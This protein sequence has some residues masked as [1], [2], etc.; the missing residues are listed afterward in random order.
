MARLGDMVSCLKCGG[1]YPIAQVM[2]RGMGRQATR[3]RGGQDRLW[4]ELDRIASHR[5]RAAHQ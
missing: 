2:P 5:H 1:I 3:L 4:R